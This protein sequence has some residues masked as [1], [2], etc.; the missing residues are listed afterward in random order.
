[1]ES[2]KA[3]RTKWK[4]W[5]IYWKEGVSPQEPGCVTVVGAVVSVSFPLP[6]MGTWTGLLNPTL[7]TR[8]WD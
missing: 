3:N 4:A 1:M 6:K 8:R 2:P 5:V 7:A